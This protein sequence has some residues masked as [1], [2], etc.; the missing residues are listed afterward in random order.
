MNGNGQFSTGRYRSL[1]TE[2]QAID[3][4]TLT[5]LLENESAGMTIVPMSFIPGLISN[6]KSAWTPF[7]RFAL[8]HHLTD[9]SRLVI[10]SE[11]VFTNGNVFD[12]DLPFSLLTDAKG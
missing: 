10:Y 11:G 9:A 5:S 7:F 12:H 3:S 1:T 2:N 4:P 8:H 6:S